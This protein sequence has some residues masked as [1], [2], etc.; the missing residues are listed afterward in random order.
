MAI[1]S[2]L[3]YCTKLALSKEEAGEVKAAVYIWSLSKIEEERELYQNIRIMVNT[4]KGG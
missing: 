3:E 2:S 1:S 4:L